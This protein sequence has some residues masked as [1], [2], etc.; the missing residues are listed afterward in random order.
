MHGRCTRW[1]D[2]RDRWPYG[3]R[4]S[5]SQRHTSYYR[6]ERAVVRNALRHAAQEYRGTGDVD[7]IVPTRQHRHSLWRAGWWD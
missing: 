4:P 2:D 3:M 1:V 7:T 6:P 5:S